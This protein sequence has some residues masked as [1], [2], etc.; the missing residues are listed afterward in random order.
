MSE[1]RSV[2]ERDKKLGTNDVYPIGQTPL[3]FLVRDDIDIG[4]DTKV[5]DVQVGPDGI[6]TVRFDDN[7]TL[8]GTS[9]IALQFDARSNRL[10]QWT[11][12]DPQGVETTVSLSNVNVVQRR[13][14]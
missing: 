12:V 11:I 10:K 1:G 13:N 9:R 7:N 14:A 4:R 3:K 6:V 5:R 2:A 8:G